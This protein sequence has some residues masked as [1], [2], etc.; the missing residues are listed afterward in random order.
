MK[1]K[2]SRFQI[3]PVPPDHAAAGDLLR[4]LCAL[5][6]FI[7]V[8]NVSGLPSFGGADTLIDSEVGRF[9]IENG[10]EDTGATNII[11]PIILSYRGFDTLG[12]SHILI[13]RHLRKQPEILE[14]YTYVPS[15]LRYG[16]S[17]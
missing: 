2:R 12:E 6:I 5:M 13:Y 11:T 17:L 8:Y 10:L 9:Y 7:L 3:A 4:V 16:V 1:K 14:H 15:V